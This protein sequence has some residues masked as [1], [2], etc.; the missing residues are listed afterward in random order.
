MRPEDFGV[1]WYNVG[2]SRDELEQL[3][4]LIDGH[5]VDAKEIQGIR[6]KLK[7]KFALLRKRRRTR[8]V[9]K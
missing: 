8:P 1:T 5:E 9:A 3:I 7:K 2:L 4:L 6:R